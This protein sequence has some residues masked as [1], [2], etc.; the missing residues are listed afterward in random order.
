MEYKVGYKFSNLRKRILEIGASYV[1]QVTENKKIG[2]DWTRAYFEDPKFEKK[3]ERGWMV[4][5]EKKS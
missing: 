2:K 3:N 1:G 5:K 4:F